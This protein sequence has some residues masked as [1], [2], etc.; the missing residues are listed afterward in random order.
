MLSQ[1]VLSLGQTGLNRVL[2]LG[3]ELCSFPGERGDSPGSDT[4]L[5]L[6]PPDSPP[7]PLCWHHVAPGFQQ[8]S[9]LITEGAGRNP[10]QR[11]AEVQ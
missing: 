3:K 4:R 1:V 7:P 2:Q 9:Y 5:P 6:L 10:F 11:R 8:L